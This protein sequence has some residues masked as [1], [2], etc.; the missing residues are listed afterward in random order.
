MQKAEEELARDTEN[1]GLHDES[2]VS[3]TF[4]ESSLQESYLPK[5]FNS[6]DFQPLENAIANH[7]VTAAINHTEGLD[8]LRPFIA[9]RL[10]GIQLQRY[11]T[12]RDCGTGSQFRIILKSSTC[13]KRPTSCHQLLARPHV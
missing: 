6:N 12:P 9:L 3:S 13:D 5:Q 1:D 4:F 7:E 10:E 2:L 8:F 11:D